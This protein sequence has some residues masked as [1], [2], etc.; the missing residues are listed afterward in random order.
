MKISLT[1]IGLLVSLTLPAAAQGTCFP[2][3]APNGQPVSYQQWYAVCGQQTVQMC[4]YLQGITP[5]PAANCNNILAA[6]YQQYVQSVLY[7][8][9]TCTQ[10]N[11]G[12][13]AC[14]SGYIA[15]CNGYLWQRSANRC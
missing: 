15:T 4:Q 1:T 9:P 7:S 10:Y 8:Q 11:A 3:T 12:A 14:L 5:V 13:R 6:S 2:G